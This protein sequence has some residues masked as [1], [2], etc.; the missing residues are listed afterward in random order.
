MC[1][2]EACLK[3]SSLLNPAAALLIRLACLLCLILK[4]NWQLFITNISRDFH[5]FRG[6]GVEG[7]G[8]KQGLNLVLGLEGNILG[9]YIPYLI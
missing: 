7:G 2:Y 6:D 5:C 8:E 1:E 3:S 4:T 9:V